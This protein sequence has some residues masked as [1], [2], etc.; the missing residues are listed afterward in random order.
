MRVDAHTG[1]INWPRYGSKGI[2]P[3]QPVLPLLL[4]EA[5]YY[6]GMVL[7]TRNLIGP[8]LHEY[9]DEYHFIGKEVDDG[10]TPEGIE[11]P[12][13]AEHLRQDGRLYRANRAN[14]SHYRHETDWFAVRTMMCACEW[15]EENAH[16]ERFVLSDHGIYIGEHNRTGKHTVPP[17]R[18]GR[19]CGRAC[20]Q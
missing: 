13:P 3:G 15:L 9:Y 10:V 16:R 12:V 7:D 19:V 2:D 17:G 14:R 11:L 20:T 8:G 4:R 18:P 5:G 6:T 1:D